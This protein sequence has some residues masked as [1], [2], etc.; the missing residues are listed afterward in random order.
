M[1]AEADSDVYTEWLGIGAGERPPNHY[2]LLGLPLFFADIAQIEASY[3]ERYAHIRRY[4]VGNRSAEAIQLLHQLSNAYQQL[5][6]PSVKQQ[7]DRELQSQQSAA[8][9][10]PIHLEAVDDDA[11]IVASNET[12]PWFYTVRGITVG[13]VVWSDVEQAMW[14]GTLGV[15]SELWQQGWTVRK[16]ARE[17][18]PNIDMSSRLQP[19]QPAKPTREPTPR[20]LRYQ[21]TDPDRRSL[22]GHLAM[23]GLVLA[24][25]FALQAAAVWQHAYRSWIWPLSSLVSI[26]GVAVAALALLEPR[27]FFDSTPVRPLRAKFGDGGARSRVLA[28]GVVFLVIGYST[29]TSQVAGR[30]WYILRRQPV[31][32]VG[33]LARD[34]H[35]TGDRLTR[36]GN[37]FGVDGQV[38][39]NLKSDEAPKI[40]SALLRLQT[41]EVNQHRAEIARRLLELV[42]DDD[43]TVQRLAVQT[44]RKWVS[45][46]ERDELVR[47]I[48]DESLPDRIRSALVYTFESFTD[49]ASTDELAGFLEDSSLRVSAQSVLTSMGSRAEPHV[50]PHL[51]SSDEDVRRTVCMWLGRFGS[52]FCLPALR[53]YEANATEGSDKVFA[54]AAINQITT[55]AGGQ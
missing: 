28:A 12:L 37:F 43:P 53:E 45:S 31:G 54:V 40:R 9:T 22:S 27:T 49:V 4:Q 17:L 55:R 7:Y 44:A 50:L 15:D 42:Y 51:A 3:Q 32:P 48:R 18:F 10:V 24:I 38:L 36:S 16:W 26:A 35:K 52:Q 46:L 1:A 21:P 39:E 41:M 23:L 25:G 8:T 13:P 34:L 2:T 30:F 5:T 11:P 33:P 29:Q 47:A 20:L 6:N 19:M 14:S